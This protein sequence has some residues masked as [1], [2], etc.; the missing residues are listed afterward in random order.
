MLFCHEARTSLVLSCPRLRARLHT[1]VLTTSSPSPPLVTRCCPN[2]RSS[3]SIP[4]GVV[5][6]LYFGLFQRQTWCTRICL[7]RWL[8]SPSLPW[9]T[10]S[11]RSFPTFGSRAFG[12]SIEPQ[13]A[14]G[15]TEAL[16][17]T[18]ADSR[19]SPIQD[20]TTIWPHFCWE[21]STM[22]IQFVVYM[23]CGVSPSRWFS[24]PLCLM[25]LLHGWPQRFIG[26]TDAAWPCSA[27]TMPTSATKA[28]R[29]L[30]LPPGIRCVP[31]GWQNSPRGM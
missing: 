15:P 30:L 23:L 8:S 29:P 31:S 20:F 18:R 13:R 10:L 19:A 5:S 2:C 17:S 16:W 27:G 9:W 6:L 14:S 25:Q 24:V 22:S 11:P 1:L 4:T 28:K 12:R 26:L 7:L 3:F 21:G